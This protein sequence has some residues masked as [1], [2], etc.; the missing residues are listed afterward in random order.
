[1]NHGLGS[2]L[3][4]MPVMFEQRVP[5][6]PQKSAFTLRSPT[7]SLSALAAVFPYEYPMS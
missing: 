4:P 2:Y 1:M 3:A 7:H 6:R 5:Q